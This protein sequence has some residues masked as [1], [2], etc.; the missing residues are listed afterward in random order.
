MSFQFEHRQ[1]KERE[2]IRNKKIEA[3]RLRIQE[4]IRLK[5]E[6]LAKAL[7]EKE[8]YTLKH[9]WSLLSNISQNFIMDTI[10]LKFT[11]DMYLSPSLTKYSVG[12]PN[13][14][15]E[16]IIDSY[17]YKYIDG[18]FITNELY[19]SDSLVKRKYDITLECSDKYFY[20]FNETKRFLERFG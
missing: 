13:L 10:Y 11:F 6:H 14:K 7:K 3:E 18:I 15:K 9:K 12:I 5:E 16:P 4:E 19:Y 17:Y 1:L 2:E 20:N 8:T